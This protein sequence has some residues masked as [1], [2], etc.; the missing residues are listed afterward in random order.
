MEEVIN[1]I[2]ET[3]PGAYDDAISEK[4]EEIGVQCLDDLQ[5]ISFEK[6]LVPPLKLVAALKIDR[7]IQ[8]RVSHNLTPE[9]SVVAVCSTPETETS[10]SYKSTPKN[11]L[12]HPLTKSSGNK[13]NL[14][15]F[16]IPYNKFPPHVT[17]SM[18]QNRTLSRPNVLNEVVRIIC[19]EVHALDTH[20]GSRFFESLAK[21][22]VGKYPSTFGL[23]LED[24][25]L[26]G[27]GHHLLQRK[28]EERMKNMNRGVKRSL[29]YDDGED[30][31][32]D[33]VE[34]KKKL[35]TK[36]DSY[37]CVNFLPKELPENE[38]PATQDEKRMWLVEEFQKVPEDRNN[39]QIK[40]YMS[41]TYATQRPSILNKQLDTVREHWP[42]LFEK[43][44]LV[45][46]F[47]KLMGISLLEVANE[48][49]QTLLPLLKKFLTSKVNVESKKLSDE[50][51]YIR[52]RLVFIDRNNFSSD[53]MLIF[54]I[55]ILIHM[56][57]QEREEIF[58]MYEDTAS[59][60]EVEASASMPHPHIAVLG[61]NDWNN[62][63][64]GNCYLPTMEGHCI[65]PPMP[66]SDAIM[67]TFAMYFVHS[68]AYP[69][70][71]AGIW[72][73]IQR[74]VFHINGEGSKVK[75]VK[76]Q[77]A[78]VHTRVASLI[79][80]LTHFKEMWRL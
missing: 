45:D 55:D 75:R 24:G 40:R 27:D 1:F 67:V 48:A 21:E 60:A 73:F 9:L 6:H 68:V 41:V 2:Q 39:E 71:T 30:D 26:L 37:G 76:R 63:P 38:T 64:L 44:Y 15:S 25:T 42:F 69:P 16:I 18:Q 28:L 22:L 36:K 59:V 65:S 34:N 11:I 20:P 72:E 32:G 17:R 53:Q 49:Y 50:K 74:L 29:H 14:Q 4:L 56:W 12:F 46:H 5:Y 7:A 62:L 13:K 19:N 58:V 51:T 66:A 79:E 47:K 8:T 78:A 23:K 35:I 31:D 43:E 33:C 54:I 80:A 57:R 77:P 70:K 52:D 61:G 3:V 10:S